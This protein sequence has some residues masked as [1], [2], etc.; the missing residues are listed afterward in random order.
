MMDDGLSEKDFVK[1]LLD[2]SIKTKGVNGILYIHPIP[3]LVK[4]VYGF[5]E[6]KQFLEDSSL[7]NLN[8]FYQKLDEF[9]DDNW[10]RL[11]NQKR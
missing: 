6:T 11:I 4:I 10:G 5:S 7:K 3:Q 2:E 9:L 1:Y 8:I